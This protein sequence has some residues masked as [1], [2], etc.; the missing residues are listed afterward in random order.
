MKN[1]LGTPNFSKIVQDFFCL[2][3]QNQK[4]VSHQ[5]I[6]S[7]RDTFRLMLQF[8]RKQ[9]RKAPSDLTLEDIDPD[10]ILEFLHYLE[11]ERK[12]TIQTRNVRLAAIRS[13]MK[14]ASLRDPQ[15]LVN[16][17]RLLVIP[18]KRT[19]HHLVGYL[20][21]K[22]INAILNAPDPLTW[23]GTRDR[24]MFAT[25][26][27]TG[28]RVSEICSLR[29]L[30]LDLDRSHSIRL[31]GKGRKER[32][33]PLWKDTI[34]QLHR[35][36]GRIDSQGSAPLFPNRN[37]DHMTRSG[38]EDRLKRAVRAAAIACP[39]LVGRAVSPHTL[40]HTTA[41]H[42]L[43]SGVS[44]SVIALWLGHESVTTTHQYIEADLAMKKRALCQLQ[45]PVILPL[46]YK[47]SDKL[48]AFLEAL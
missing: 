20:S 33:I 1:T 38:V 46:R 43:Q 24:V 36:L 14:Y 2:Y 44:E 8:V 39:S 42:L 40:R 15:S 16:T 45:K 35:W 25:F 30:D 19:D 37:G 4:N 27:N 31:H 9:R 5:T 41:M 21:L 48:L 6:A 34:L 22:E 47:P 29:I 28:A 12:N 3:L 32:S 11:K 13:F 23:S 26:Y 10:L 7:Y 17:E 18:L